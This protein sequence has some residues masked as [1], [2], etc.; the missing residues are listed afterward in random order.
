MPKNKTDDGFNVTAREAQD[1]VKD[2]APVEDGKQDVPTPAVFLDD[3]LYSLKAIDLR[4]LKKDARGPVKNARVAVQ[5]A[6][7]AL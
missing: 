4:T 2:E 7:K 6:M 5:E 1:I 3:A